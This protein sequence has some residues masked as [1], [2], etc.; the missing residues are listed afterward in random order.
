[1]NRLTATRHTLDFNALSYDKFEELCFWL[2]EDSGEYDKVEYY[3]GAGDKKRDVIG[4]SFD[5]EQDYFQC[6]RYDNPSYGVLK[7]EID[8]MIS[9]IQAGEIKK[10][11]RI[12]F[13]LS[14][15]ASPDAKDRSKQ[16]ASDNDLPEPT[17]WEPVILDKKIKKNPDALANFFGIPDNKGEDQ[18]PE[19][20]T[21]GLIAY[22]TDEYRFH[23]INNGPASAVDCSWSLLGF[24]WPGYPGVPPS[25]DLSPG[26]K[27]EMRISMSGQFMGQKPIKELRLHFKFRDSK[28]NWFYSERYLTPEL[29]KSGT[30]YI[31]NSV[32][33][34]YMPARPLLTQFTV[35]S[36]L[37]LAR[38]G[39]NATRLVYFTQ[40]GD[41]KTLKIN[42]SD[43]LTIGWQFTQEE[44]EA[45]FAELAEKRFAQM[46][47]T[48]KFEEEFSVTTFLKPTQ[49]TGFEAYQELR[50]SIK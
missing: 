17:F 2:V 19:L 49:K 31:I 13:V 34:K 24:G 48:G 1:M 26:Q 42:I 21:T 6:K 32:A 37:P 44:I 14:S 5:D 10:P 3:G 30:V 39:L 50:D 36:I 43:T 16:Y 27:V 4:Y 41:Q 18:I 25:F 46:L 45:A 15:A 38:T 28:N 7:E 11:R 47:R 33:G 29:A 40:G 35:D 20:D 8:G 12:Y 9:H 22:S 23:I